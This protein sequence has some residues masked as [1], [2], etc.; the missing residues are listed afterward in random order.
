[1]ANP[2]GDGNKPKGGGAQAPIAPRRSLPPR[3]SRPKIRRVQAPTAP[4]PPR[5]PA[6]PPA[7][8]DTVPD[9]RLELEDTGEGA[10][11]TVFSRP[12]LSEQT[13]VMSNAPARPTPSTTIEPS[14]ITERMLVKPRPV[15]PPTREATPLQPA[16]NAPWLMDARSLPSEVPPSQAPLHIPIAR[17]PVAFPV[18]FSPAPPNVRLPTAPEFSPSH[19]PVSL[20]RG[21]VAFVL[22]VAPLGISLAA[23]A[24]LAVR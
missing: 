18:H 14:P 16:P 17:S 10:T 3:P 20:L 15:A 9:T 7:F 2:P 21:V 8:V 5:A 13:A 19:A 22:F 11:T 23:L 12:P 4:L 6:P 24:A 1:M